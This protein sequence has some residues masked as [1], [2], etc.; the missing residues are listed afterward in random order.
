MTELVVVERRPETAVGICRLDDPASHN[1]LSPLMLDQL[2][3]ALDDLDA[4]PGVRCI[5][6][7]GSVKTF[8]SGADIRALAEG[9]AGT[10]VGVSGEETRRVPLDEVVGKERSL[11]PDMYTLA[12]VLAEMEK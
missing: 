9:E 10:M 2:G 4:D 11:D 12:Q 1:A 8:A 5:V 3:A 6:I 7:C